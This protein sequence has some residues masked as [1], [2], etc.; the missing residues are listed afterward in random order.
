M[1]GSIQSS[2]EE[3]SY[4]NPDEAGTLGTAKLARR[5]LVVFLL[6]QLALMK[7]R[8]LEMG[9][10]STPNEHLI[11]LSPNESNLYGKGCNL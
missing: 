4:L 8:L 11:P 1:E 9:L 10:Y 5:K 3:N 6:R 7:L 2:P